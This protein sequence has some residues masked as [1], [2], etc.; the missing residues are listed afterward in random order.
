ML[1]KPWQSGQAPNGLLNE[2]SRGCGTSVR[3]VALPA[4][5]PL[6]EAMDSRRPG[7]VGGQLDRE[8]GPASLDVGGLDRVGQ[9]RAKVA[10]D[11]QAID[12]HLEQR[13]ILEGRGIDILERHRLAIDVQ[14]SETLPAERGDSFDHRIDQTGE[15]WLRRRPLLFG[16]FG[17]RR[18]LFVHPRHGSEGR[19]RDD[20]HVEADQNPGPLAQLA[21]PPGDDFGGFANDLASAV[22]AVGVADPSVEQAEIVVDLGGGAHRR[23]GIADAVLL[24]DGNRR[25]DALDRVDIGLFHPFEELAGVGRQRLDIAALPLGIDGVERKRRL[26]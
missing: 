26:A 3:D 12:D 16:A 1:P 17:R 18:F 20:R 19:R 4:F 24:A 21:E 10:V 13:P 6:A 22:P 25:A 7:R 9:P 5:E 8:R 11:L 15:V 2:N 14:P 23:T